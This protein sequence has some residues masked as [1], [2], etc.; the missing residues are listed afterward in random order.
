MK[1]S[2]QVTGI[3]DDGVGLP[4]EQTPRT[5]GTGL[6]IMPYRANLIG[7]GVTI[8]RGPREGTVVTCSIPLGQAAEAAASA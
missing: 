2:W 8:G 5:G 4:A 7:G 6:D 1:V 3:R